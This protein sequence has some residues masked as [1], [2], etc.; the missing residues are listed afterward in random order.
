MGMLHRENLDKNGA[1]WCNLGVPK[2]AITKLKIN[3]FNV[4]KS[5]TTKVNCHISLRDQSRCT[6]YTRI[7]TFGIYKGVWGAIPQKQKKI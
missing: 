2:S 3:N 4:S 1:I 5:T 7:N 6:C